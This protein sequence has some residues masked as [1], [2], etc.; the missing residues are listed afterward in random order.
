[1]HII[2][3]TRNQQ[4]KQTQAHAE[5]RTLDDDHNPETQWDMNPPS[6]FSMIGHVIFW[7]EIWVGRIITSKMLVLVV[8]DARFRCEWRRLDEFVSGGSDF[9]YMEIW[10]KLRAFRSRSGTKIKGLI[11]GFFYAPIGRL[12]GL[13]KWPYSTHFICQFQ[14]N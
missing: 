12:T 9:F 14:I 13:T 3:N 6:L 5:T 8:L 1:M 7:R 10:R 2:I 4:W 11:P